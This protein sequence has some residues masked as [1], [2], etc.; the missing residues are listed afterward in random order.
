[1]RQAAASVTASDA[2]S[3]AMASDAHPLSSDRWIAGDNFINNLTYLHICIE[4][5]ALLSY[6]LTCT[7]VGLWLTPRSEVSVNP[8]SQSLCWRL[9]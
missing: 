5:C 2:C 8:Y 3:G 6:K 4:S 1:M 9:Q 7:G